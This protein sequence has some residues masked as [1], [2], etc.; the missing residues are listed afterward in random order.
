MKTNVHKTIIVVGLTLCL[1][2][3]GSATADF[4]HYTQDFQT[5]AAPGFVVTNATGTSSSSFTVA[6]L[7]GGNDWYKTV[8][9]R[10][11]GTGS[12]AALSAVQVSGVAGNAFSISTLAT[13]VSFISGV[14]CSAGLFF[15]GANSNSTNDSYVVD[16]NPNYGC[17]RLVEWAGS[18]A[19][20]LPSTDQ[21]QQPVIKNFAL[22]KTYLLEVD[23]AYSGS[24]LT[25][26]CKAVE[27]GNPQNLATY[28]YVDPAPR[29]GQYFGFR[30]SLGSGA[31]GTFEMD[32]DNLSVVPEP[33]TIALLGL[34]SLFFARKRNA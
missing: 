32:F 24:S 8:L 12:A 28:T 10:T 17:I 31:T 14:N 2:I 29:S 26:V 3:A 11:S 22:G 13:P 4:V 25:L 5:G 33:A 23:G 20:V 1:L 21:T 27:V 6:D 16:I 30:T 34:G 7:G 18:A 19:T 9:T 15:L